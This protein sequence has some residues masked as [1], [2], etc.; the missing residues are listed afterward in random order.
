MQSQVAELTLHN[1]R[2]EAQLLPITQTQQDKSASS[3]DETRSDYIQI[4]NVSSESTSI[5]DR[6]VD[7]RVRIQGEISLLSIVSRVVEFLRGING[8]SLMS[9]EAETL[10][11]TDPSAPSNHIFFR[12]RI[13]VKIYLSIIRFRV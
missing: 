2:L 13:E 3:S 9:M 12:L 11:A 6:I 1:Q 4:N 10:M 5:D 8:L 7:V